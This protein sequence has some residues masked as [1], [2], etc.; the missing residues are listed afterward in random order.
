[1]SYASV[2]HNLRIIFIK[3]K[4]ATVFLN[5]LSNKAWKILISLFILAF[6]FPGPFFLSVE[7]SFLLSLPPLFL[8]PFQGT[9]FT[10]GNFLAKVF[11]HIHEESMI[12]IEHRYVFF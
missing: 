1:L 7:Q 9:P 8:K 12:F 5:I 10:G 3:N 4:K 6:P 11:S 2:K